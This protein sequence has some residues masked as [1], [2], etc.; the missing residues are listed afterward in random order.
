[1]PPSPEVTVPLLRRFN[2]TI[3]LVPE[4]SCGSSTIS[5][6]LLLTVQGMSM[7]NPSPVSTV[8]TATRVPATPAGTPV[9]FDSLTSP[10]I[11]SGGNVLPNGGLAPRP[12]TPP[13]MPQKRVFGSPGT[14]TILLIERPV[15]NP[16]LRGM[17]PESL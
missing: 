6:T 17:P 4:G 1:M 14:L 3:S 13:A 9:T 7:H 15:K 2:H 10:R 5:L 12:I 8:L 11:A 16:V